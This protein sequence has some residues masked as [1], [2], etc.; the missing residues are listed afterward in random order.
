MNKKGFTLFEML[1]VLFILCLLFLI[2]VPVVNNIIKQSKIGTQKDSILGYIRAINNQVGMTGT[3]I[4][5]LSI[6]VPSNHILK[7]GENDIE[8]GILNIS[9]TLP[10][11][12]EIL[13]DETNTIIESAK[14][15]IDG[16]SYDY[17][18]SDILL[19]ENDY[20]TTIEP[21]LY[22]S[23][24]TLI[25]SWDDLV[26]TYG[27]IIDK[28]YTY[29]TGAETDNTVSSSSGTNVLNTYA[30]STGVKLV[31]KEGI[32]YIGTN[33]FRGNTT[34]QT[35]IFPKSLKEIGNYAFRNDS[36][37]G[38]I[39]N[40]TFNI[41]SNLEKIGRTA[42]MGNYKIE[43]L[44]IPKSVKEIGGNAF[45]G[46]NLTGNINRLEKLVFGYNSSLETIGD[47]SFSSNTKIKYINFPSKLTLI[48]DFAFQYCF[49]LE[50]IFIPKSVTKIGLRAFEGYAI[51]STFPEGILTNYNKIEFESG[52]NLEYIGESAFYYNEK[53]TSITIPS[54]VKTIGKNAFALPKLKNVEFE[55]TT[56]WYYVESES[57]T[58]GTPM[59]VTDPETNA[60]NFRTTYLQKWLKRN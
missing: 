38:N 36:N 33:S 28:D 4:D 43:E 16:N 45:R 52:S 27:L 20:C 53:I 10:D 37:Q 34:L 1:C 50:E 19:S 13:F 48:D 17:S 5:T 54:K 47:S 11:Y 41:K 14:F 40:I 58:E 22:N 29:N 32:T 3:N 56:G 42:F 12:A 59:T 49:S 23:S 31:I 18:V 7:T 60:T 44:F 30:L 57:A 46:M 25:A 35:I 26:N 8:L 2:T 51:D 15:C 39:T 9:G 55:T 6:N 24:N 21:G